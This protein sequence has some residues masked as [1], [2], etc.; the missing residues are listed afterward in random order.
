MNQVVQECSHGYYFWFPALRLNEYKYLKY[1]RLLHHNHS[2]AHGLLDGAAEVIDS[3]EF[4][5]EGI[6]MKRTMKAIIL[7]TVL[8]APFFVAESNAG[9]QVHLRIGPPACR[10]VEVRPAR[11]WR[12]AVWVSGHWQYDRGRHVWVDGHWLKHRRGF[13]YIQPTWKKSHRGWHHV[14]GHW[15]KRR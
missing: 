14:P 1:I 3:T 11:P 9:V 4:L 8:A 15:V 6:E 5:T 2:L 10:V 7:A 13:H 12:N